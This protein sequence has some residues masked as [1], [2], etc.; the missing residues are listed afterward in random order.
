LRVNA[1][2]DRL[3]V[4]ALQLL[5]QRQQH[6]ASQPHFAKAASGSEQ[7]NPTGATVAIYLTPAKSGGNSTRGDRH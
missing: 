3:Q 4:E 2:F 7:L 5:H 6:G 1:E